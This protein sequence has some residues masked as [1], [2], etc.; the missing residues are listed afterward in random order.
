MN[1]GLTPQKE[2]I[3]MSLSSCHVSIDTCKF[4]VSVIFIQCVFIFLVLTLEELLSCIPPLVPYSPNAT[5]ST[6][7]TNVD[8]FNRPTEVLLWDTFFREVNEFNFD[9]QPDFQG[10]QLKAPYFET[11]FIVN[12]EEMLRHAIN[13]NI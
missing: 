12:N 8:C 11:R 1:V 5:T 4:F 7:T 2:G 9:Q 10:L 3:S 13:F 6:S